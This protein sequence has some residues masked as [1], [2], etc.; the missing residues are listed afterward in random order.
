MDKSRCLAALIQKCEFGQRLFVTLSAPSL[1][2]LWE[3]LMGS[4]HLGLHG[5]R[6]TAP[7]SGPSR[8]LVA[9]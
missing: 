2:P 3:A 9:L 8:V 6:F 4:G 1:V 7:I 5:H